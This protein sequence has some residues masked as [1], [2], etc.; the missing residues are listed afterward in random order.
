[1]SQSKKML[2]A[3]AGS[4]GENGWFRTWGTLKINRKQKV[5]SD[6]S[7]NIYSVGY[8]ESLNTT[9]T[10]FVTEGV[11][12][13]HT[14]DG[15]LQWERYFALRATPVTSFKT[16]FNDLDFDSSGNIA[17]FGYDQ[18][19]SNSNG[20][21]IFCVK[22]NP[23][24]DKVFDVSFVSP[25]NQQGIYISAGK[26]DTS[27]DSIY[28]AGSRRNGDSFS[29]TDAYLAKVNSDGTSITWARKLETSRR[30]ATLY[31]ITLD[32][33]GNVIGVGLVNTNNSG[34]AILVKYNSSGV[35]QWQRKVDGGSKIVF[36]GVITDSSGNIYVTG[37]SSRGSPEFTGLIVL[38]YNSSGVLQ[39]KRR[40]DATSGSIS[41][42]GKGIVFAPDGTLIISGYLGW[43][44]PTQAYAYGGYILN[45]DTNGNFIYDRAFGGTQYLNLGRTFFNG[46]TVQGG[47]MVHV[48][49]TSIPS[50][51]EQSSSFEYDFLA[52]KLPVDGS[53]TGTYRTNY[54]YEPV[55]LSVIP[56][57]MTDSAGDLTDSG[58]SLTFASLGSPPNFEIYN[59]LT[60][61]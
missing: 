29:A 14:K 11:I 38:K 28:F 7:G 13:K 22:Y 40:V 49:E 2:M 17:C 50:D 12:T 20:T 44:S 57:G 55:G 45:M 6:A 9:S 18:S 39:W 51:K 52:V 16:F 4:G 37:D 46:V 10:D 23:A 26:I 60:V 34:E 8:S 61:I 47:S 25:P 43:I 33:S 30:N 36:E 53:L 5:A 41:P 58:S 19:R 27:D 24:G 35:L 3:A 15:E 42:E 1:M 32:S 21:D 48:G 54:I 56:D 59:R 31:D